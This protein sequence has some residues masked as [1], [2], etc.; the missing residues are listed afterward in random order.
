MLDVAQGHL[1]G[2]IF[3]AILYGIYFTLFVICLFVFDSSEERTTNRVVKY[4]VIVMFLVSTAHIG[5]TIASLQ[6]GFFTVR[7][8][9]PEQ[10]FNSKAVPL[11]LVNK[12]LYGTNMVLGDA[13]MIYRL[14]IIYQRNWL[15]IILPI[16]L[17]IATGT[18]IGVTIW[19]FSK[20][21][22]GQTAF[23]IRVKSIAPALFSVPLATNLV[24]TGL[25]IWRIRQA[26]NKSNFVANPK[27]NVFYRRVIRNT[28]ESCAIYP[29]V[30]AVTLI[31]YCRND[32]GQD[33][34]TGSM[35]QVV[36]IVPT[37]MWLQHRL[38]QSELGSVRGDPPLPVSQ[39]TIEFMP[40]R[41]L[42]STNLDTVGTGYSTDVE[43]SPVKE[44]G[45]KEVKL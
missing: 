28:I 38:G 22:P 12:S 44:D 23:A 31:L 45:N 4:T 36:S 35:A 13:L 6:A 21:L 18:L 9:T 25:I 39:R 1:F 2:T 34:L 41:D 40:N 3:E 33:I 30:L 19:E 42:R 20:L 26:Q 37:L 27:L 11:N 7:P 14:W 24:I 43:V 15:I 16:L 32:N 5:G 29:F 17:T 10:Y 8:E